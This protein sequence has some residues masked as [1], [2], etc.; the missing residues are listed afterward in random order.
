[1]EPGL[2][3][4]FHDVAAAA[5]L[6]TPRPGVELRWTEGQKG[7][8]GCGYNRDDQEEEPEFPALHQFQHN[9]SHVENPNLQEAVGK[10]AI[11]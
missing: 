4:A 3:A 1:V 11:Y 6:R 9:G 7:S 2:V 8:H 5:K 10:T